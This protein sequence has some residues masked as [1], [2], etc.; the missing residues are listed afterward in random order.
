MLRFRS[1][2]SSLFSDARCIIAQ[3]WRKHIM[4]AITEIGISLNYS[5]DISCIGMLNLV[6]KNRFSLHSIL[7]RNCCLCFVN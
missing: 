7:K 1:S 3:E 2:K 6:V 4:Q 5:G